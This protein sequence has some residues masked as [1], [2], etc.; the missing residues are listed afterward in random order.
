MRYKMS[1]IVTLCASHINGKQR[2]DHINNMIKSSVAQTIIAP[3]Y[4]SISCI[5]FWKQELDKI[6][7]QYKNNNYVKIFYQKEART[8]FE[9]YKYLS[10]QID[11]IL[12]NHVWCL[13][14]D[15][16]DYLHPMRNASYLKQIINAKT[17]DICV[18]NGSLCVSSWKDLHINRKMLNSYLP[19][20]KNSTF[21][22]S[23][24][25]YVTYG[26]RLIA[27]KKFC[28]LL[29]TWDKIKTF[30]CDVVLVAVLRNV[31]RLKVERGLCEWLYAYNQTDTHSRTCQSLGIEYYV[32]NYDNNFFDAL[33][34]EFNFSWP[35]AFP[36]GYAHIY[37]I[38]SHEE[39]IEK[40]KKK[41]EKPLEVE[42]LTFLG[43][44]I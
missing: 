33:A 16:D 17:D 1:S 4:I 20:G 24:N 18:Q 21:V 8:Q 2:L 23:S 35:I 13:F 26:V 14:V 38:K 25:E 5:G 41:L 7:N 6:I 27:F 12:G 40:L 10:D 9:H 11:D 15:D 34:T 43:E 28:R 32:E 22:L 29:Q 19:T 31:C 42:N 30:Q 37:T 39:A 44:N 3:L 36:K